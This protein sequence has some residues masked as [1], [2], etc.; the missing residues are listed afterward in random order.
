MWT[1]VK[2]IV[3]LVSYPLKPLPLSLTIFMV[4]G[5]SSPHPPQGGRYLRIS[6][7][8]YEF[9]LRKPNLNER[10]TETETQRSMLKP[11]S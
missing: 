10:E 2:L 4:Y 7:C 3:L 5:M 11:E 1:L 9:S 6:H 8:G